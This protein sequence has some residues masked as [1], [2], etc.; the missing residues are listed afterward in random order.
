MARV[1]SGGTKATCVAGA[2]VSRS[3]TI[4]GTLASCTAGADVGGNLRTGDCGFT[5]AG[6]GGAAGEGL[7]GF[8]AA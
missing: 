4:R 5:E 8:T 1:G 7:F 3:G 2:T 6:G